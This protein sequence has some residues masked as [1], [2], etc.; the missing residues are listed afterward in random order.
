M[1]SQIPLIKAIVELIKTVFDFFS[2]K[3]PQALPPVQIININQVS[4]GERRRDAPKITVEPEMKEIDVPKKESNSL[5]V[6]LPPAQKQTNQ[7]GP[8]FMSD[9]YLV[10]LAVDLREKLR[11]RD[12]IIFDDKKGSQE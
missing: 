7:E 12:R 9:E 8:E 1:L 5:V 2:P 6:V 3:K 10:D 11:P 4:V